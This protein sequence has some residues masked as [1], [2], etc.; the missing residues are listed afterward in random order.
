MIYEI[1]S[2]EQLLLKC[3]GTLYRTQAGSAYSVQAMGDATRALRLRCVVA[4]QSIPH[5]RC[6]NAACIL[7][8]YAVKYYTAAPSFQHNSLTHL[9]F[10]LS[11]CVA[12]SS[13]ILTH[14]SDISCRTTERQRSFDA[15]PTQITDNARVALLLHCTRADGLLK[16][17]NLSQNSKGVT[18]TSQK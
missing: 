17:P 10:L 18:M 9:V 7:R 5:K 6:V 15:A 2:L 11:L 1:P 8:Y 16:V 4:T 14:R 13:I 12:S 3:Y